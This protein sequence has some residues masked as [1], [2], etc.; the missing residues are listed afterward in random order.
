MEKYLEN[1]LMHFFTKYR[2]VKYKKNETILRIED[3]PQGLYY[4]SKGFVRIYMI[5]GNGQELTINIFK[6]GSFFP[7]TWAIADIPN[8]YFY[9]AMT[10]TE[11]WRAPKHDFLN[12]IKKDK[13]IL[14]EMSRRILMGLNSLSVRLEYLILGDAYHRVTNVLLLLGR[15]FGEIKKGNDVYI[16]FPVTQQEI[17]NLAGLTRETVSVEIKKLEKNGI[18]KRKNPVYIISNPK[19][20]KNESLIYVEGCPLPYFF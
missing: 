10:P 3:P 8:F 4:I 2:Q 7:L 9:E 19:K 14:Y 13:E 16:N 15:R 20:L 5:I 11:I 12:F 17:A 1:K 6:T 18:I